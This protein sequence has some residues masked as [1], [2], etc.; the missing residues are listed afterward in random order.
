MNDAERIRAMQDEGRLDPAQADRLLHALDELR[1]EGPP[2]G[3]TDAFAAAGTVSDGANP[4]PRAGDDTRW[5]RLT[6]LAGDLDVQHDPALTVPVATQ[7]DGEELPLV[8][9]GEH[10]RSG[11]RPP[12]RNG[13]GWLDRLVDGMRMHSVNLRLPSGFGL[14]LRAKAGDVTVRDVAAVRGHLLAGDFDARGVR[15]IDL[16]MQAGDADVELDPDAGD[17]RIYVTVG[18][19]SVRMPKDVDADVKASVKVG[20]LRCDAPLQGARGGFAAS[21]EATLGHGGPR[22]VLS[23]TTGDLRVELD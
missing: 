14:D 23:V 13:S 4:E 2:E 7:D 9:E 12:D 5:V 16:S 8:P 19:L 3:A 11:Q 18:D 10:Y 17:H 15:R 21:T 22:V 1:R 6:M 20:E